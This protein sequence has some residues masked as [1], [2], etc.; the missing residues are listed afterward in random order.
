L[1][2]VVAPA[3]RLLFVPPFPAVIVNG[4]VP[5]VIAFMFAP[6]ED[7]PAI[8]MTPTTIIEF[9]RLRLGPDRNPSRRGTANKNPSETIGVNPDGLTSANGATVPAG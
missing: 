7:T 5:G 1:I 9:H 8:A 6:Q 2:V 3:I 4:Y